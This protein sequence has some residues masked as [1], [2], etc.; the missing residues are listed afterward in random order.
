MSSLLLSIY[1]SFDP[2]A[3]H[4]GFYGNKSWAQ[5]E[6]CAKCEKGKYQPNRGS[7]NC[8]RCPEDF[9]TLREGSKSAGDCMVPFLAVN[10][11]LS[12]TP[13]DILWGLESV[14]GVDSE[15]KIIPVTLLIIS[16]W[17]D[18]RLV[19]GGALASI[20]RT[21]EWKDL[22]RWVPDFTIS[23]EIDT[24]ILSDD[25]ELIPLDIGGGYTVGARPCSPL[26][27]H[28]VP[29]TVSFFFVLGF[30]SSNFPCLGQFFLSL[31]SFL[32]L[33]S[34]PIGVSRDLLLCC[35]ADHSHNYHDHRNSLAKFCE[36]GGKDQPRA[37]VVYVSL[38]H[39]DS[40]YSD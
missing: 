31:G 23:N 22:G 6:S 3:S 11:H 17:R 1:V 5:Q 26:L 9:T 13:V 4:Q 36:E 7:S 38:W 37:D 40:S 27:I 28:S 34:W 2:S 21:D 8:N 18:D 19:Q 30:F 16:S 14:Q 12:P 20:L 32:V 24:V 39:A 29:L 15:S 10:P 25:V 33:I 35:R